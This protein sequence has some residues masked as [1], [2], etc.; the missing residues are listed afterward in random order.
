[1]TTPVRQDRARALAL[2]AGA[3][4][5]ISLTT[6]AAPAATRRGE[7]AVPPD[8]TEHLGE[9]ALPHR[10]YANSRATTDSTITAAK[11]ATMTEA[12]S[13]EMPGRGLFGNYA[14]TPLIVGDTVYAQDLTSNVWALSLADGSVKWSKNYDDPVIGP[15]GIGVGYDKAFAVIGRGRVVALDLETGEEVWSRNVNLHPQDGVSIQPTVVDGL[16]LLSTFPGNI[17]EQDF[18]AGVRGVLQALDQRTGKRVWK[19]DTVKGKSLW[20]SN[21][22]NAGGGAWY[23]PAVDLERG[24]AYW[25]IG[26]PAPWPGTNEFPGGTSRKGPNLYSDSVVAVGLRDGKLRWYQQANPHDLFDHD[27]QLTMLVDDADGQQLVIASGKLGIVFAYDA[28]TGDPVWETPVGTHLNDDLQE[29]TTP[30]RVSPGPL[31]GVIT[32]MAHHEG[33]IYVPVVENDAIYLPDTPNFVSD[34]DLGGGEGLLVAI[35]AATGDILWEHA[36]PNGMNLGGAT[37]VNDIVLTSTNDGTFYA[38]DRQTG[39]ELFTYKA[40]GPINGWPAVFGDTILVPVGASEPPA[41]V[42]LRLG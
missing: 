20:G 7:T 2:L 22:V 16:V 13:K 18:P 5:V 37:V 25:G 24:I 9:W 26:N 41:L 15:N 29:L 36:L 27:L 38:L 30:R 33:V 3:A 6:A 42:A 14:S 31:G 21:D 19:F 4:L 1:M 32:P 10:D 40:G 34:F 35:D 17:A 12:W 8:V 11:V 28:K 39:D 23:P